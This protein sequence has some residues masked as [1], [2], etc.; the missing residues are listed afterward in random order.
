[1]LFLT[2]SVFLVNQPNLAALAAA[3]VSSQVEMRRLHKQ[4]QKF[5]TSLFL[6][7]LFNHHISSNSFFYPPTCSPL[8]HHL[9]LADTIV[10]VSFFNFLIDSALIS[11]FQ[12]FGLF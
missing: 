11:I 10:S 2:E 1:M 9:E 12:D 4:V 7:L 6:S 3:S 5:I 8:L